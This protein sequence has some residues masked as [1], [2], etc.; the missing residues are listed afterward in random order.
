[1]TVLQSGC[2]QYGC[3]GAQEEMHSSPPQR[4]AMMCKRGES[5]LR[6]AQVSWPADSSVP[7]STGLTH[8]LL[9]WQLAA[10]IVTYL[11]MCE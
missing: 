8:P 5:G 10:S 2:G 11:E 1:M 6:L 9:D 4:S 7:A 3:G